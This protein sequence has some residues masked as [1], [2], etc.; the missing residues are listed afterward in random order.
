[1]VFTPSPMLLKLLYNRGSLHNLPQ[2]QGVAFSIKN[3]L[4]TACLTGLTHVKLGDVVVPAERI[5]LDLGEGELRPGASLGAEGQRIDLPV[6]RTLTFVLDTPA[7]AEGMH[8]LQV[9]FSTDVFGELSVEIEDA[10]ASHD[11]RVR[12]PRSEEDDYSEAAIQAR[13]AFAEQ[14]TQQEF[15]HLKQYSFDPHALR[16]NCEHFVGVA[17]VPVGLAGPLHV[18]GEHAQGEFLI[19]LATTEGT[20]VAS[21]NRGIQV[22]NMCGGV[23]CTVIGDAMQRAPVFVFEDA[24]GARD[25]GRWVAESLE[26]IRPEAESTSRVAKLQYIDT[27]SRPATR[28][29]KTWWAAPLSPLVPGFWRTTKVRPSSISTWSQTL[30]P[31]RKPAR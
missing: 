3:R 15:S 26:Q 12:I 2:G 18:D 25:F 30:L 27:Y 23:K 22:L 9:Q 17:Q 5:Q 8:Q 19:P 10:I 21:Y 14:F 4:D 24:R 29:A 31:T 20:L 7:L 6:G 1:M 28:P 11:G 13:Q 16:G